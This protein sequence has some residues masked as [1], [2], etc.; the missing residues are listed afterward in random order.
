MD[1]A[2]IIEDGDVHVDMSG[3]SREDIIEF[4]YRR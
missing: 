4:N 1:D 3:L 2:V